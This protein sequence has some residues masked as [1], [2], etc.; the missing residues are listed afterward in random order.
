MKEL[1]NGRE[2]VTLLVKSAD[3]VVCF[4]LP[5]NAPTIFCITIATIQNHNFGLLR[6][7]CSDESR[8]P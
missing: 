5:S 6:S 4:L 7:R 3:V 2:T 8:N 1:V